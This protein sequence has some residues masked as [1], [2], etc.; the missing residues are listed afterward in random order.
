MCFKSTLINV[1]TDFLQ[2]TWNAHKWKHVL[3]QQVLQIMRFI[4]RVLLVLIW[5]ELLG[6]SI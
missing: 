1:T 2:N 3:Q 5:S 6:C 4:N